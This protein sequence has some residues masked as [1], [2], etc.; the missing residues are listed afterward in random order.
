MF[1][2]PDYSKI[3]GNEV[4]SDYDRPVERPMSSQIILEEK[5]GEIRELCNMLNQ[6]TKRFC[7]D[8]WDKNSGEPHCLDPVLCFLGR[9]SEK[10][11]ETVQDWPAVLSILPQCLPTN[12]RFSP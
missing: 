6:L 4:G 8:S 11:V 5:Q 3:V 10:P 7:C 2:K 9:S 12:M 1:S